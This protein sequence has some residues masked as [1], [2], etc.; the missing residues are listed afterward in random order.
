[1]I[2]RIRVYLL[3]KAIQGLN[4]ILSELTAL[5]A[6]EALSTLNKSMT[7]DL[8]ILIVDQSHCDLDESIGDTPS[9]SSL[10]TWSARAKM[11]K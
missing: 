10:S 3:L 1:M 4:A 11:G 7:G 6:F 9:R 8:K 5:L 2:A